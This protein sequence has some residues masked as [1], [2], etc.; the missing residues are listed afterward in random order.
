MLIVSSS[1]RYAACAVVNAK[2]SA[3]NSG[4][5]NFP[6]LLFQLRLRSK[7]KQTTYDY[8]EKFSLKNQI[9]TSKMNCHSAKAFIKPMRH[10]LNFRI[11]CQNLSMSTKDKL[12][13]LK[14]AY[15]SEGRYQSPSELAKHLSNNVLYYEPKK[16]KSGVII[17]N[18][19][20]G[21]PLKADKDGFIGLSE[22]MPELASILG[23][24]QIRVVKS[25]Q[26]FASGCVLLASQEEGI[27]RLKNCLNRSR[28]NNILD[29]TFY[30]ITN[31]LPRKKFTD[32][33]V[34]LTM[35]KI[36][37]DKSNLTQGQ[38]I[39]P[40]LERILHSRTGLRKNKDVS[41]FSVQAQVMSSSS[42][43][44]ASLFRIEPSTTRKNCVAVYCADMLS[45]ILGDQH[46]GYRAK[47]VLGKMVRISPQM[48]PDSNAT[49]QL[50]PEFFLKSLGISS[51]QQ[52]L[53]PLHMHLGRICL[54]RYH[55]K[56][57]DLVIHAPFR[58]YFLGTADCLDI[59]IDFEDIKND[60]EIRMAKT[61]Q[62]KKQSNEAIGA[63]DIFPPD[64][65]E[66]KMK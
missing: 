1:R 11:Q 3:K 27:S 26:R 46:Y 30:A 63:I 4:I 58:P 51:S 25:V 18:K 24:Q 34:D 33:V 9:H 45:P 53:I 36:R 48:A 47:M 10:K 28:N 15:A 41:R 42:N 23:L 54:P 57:K 8:F 31:G 62:K 60:T 16:D 5:L 21:V 40:V 49:T 12:K 52:H 65:L 37:D 7:Q 38:S 59:K 14:E 64:E 19:P 50:L 66:N 13:T 6:A 32:E 20:A 2:S 43:G 55:G 22:A 44:R 35:E 56:G 39:Q 17:V 61:V 29:E